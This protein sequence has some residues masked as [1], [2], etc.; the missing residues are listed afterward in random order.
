LRSGK[1]AWKDEDHPELKDGSAEWVRLMR[2]E[3]EKRFEQ[4]EQRRQ[5]T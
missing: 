2:A 4:I 1:G 3:C 5:R